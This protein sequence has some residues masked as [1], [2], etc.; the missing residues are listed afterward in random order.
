MS[1]TIRGTVETVTQGQNMMGIYSYRLLISSGD[2]FIRMTDCGYSK[3]NIWTDDDIGKTGIFEYGW[4]LIE[5]RVLK[6][7]KLTNKQGERD[8]S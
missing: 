5:G 4:D 2:K 7:C 6:S 8:V 3:P 1:K